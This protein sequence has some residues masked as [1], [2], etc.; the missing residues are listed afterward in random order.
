MTVGNKIEKEPLLQL[1]VSNQESSSY[2]AADYIPSSLF[3][4][5]LIYKANSDAI[6]WRKQE[7][8]C[9]PDSGI[10]CQQQLTAKF[11]SSLRF[12]SNADGKSQ[13]V[14]QQRAVK[15]PPT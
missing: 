8:I 6:I 9:L 3:A 15:V 13:L 14:K 12:S 4:L 10:S 7:Q 2:T 1:C 5:F 11:W